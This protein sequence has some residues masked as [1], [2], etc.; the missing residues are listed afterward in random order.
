MSGVYGSSS[1]T[2]SSLKMRLAYFEDIT[3][4]PIVLGMDGIVKSAIVRRG[5]LQEVR[6][7]YQNGDIEVALLPTPDALRA[8][9]S[10]LVPASATSAVGAS[11]MFM[12]FSKKLP[13]EIKRVLVDENDLGSEFLARMLLSKKLMMRPEFV[14]SKKP[15]DPA[16][17]DLM[18]PDGFD[19]YLLVGRNCFFVRRDAFAFSMDLTMAWYELTKLPYV[20][21]CW[22]VRKG[23][24]L[25]TMEREIG[26]V[27]RR[28]EASRELVQ[29]SAERSR[30]MESGVR[31]VY[32]KA[33]I[34]RFDPQVIASLR[35]YAKEL[36][37]SRILSV[38]PMAV[39]TPPAT[40]KKAGTV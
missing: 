38:Q 12:L 22:V 21:N 11:R 5:T 13:T 27:A 36:M 4:L 32:E 35:L 7:L 9:N 30:V 23:L 34:S 3:T 10:V 37:M 25:G 19:A 8:N 17:Y 20:I 40:M 26:D 33:L 15:L 39:Y 1:K 16:E 28:N 31:A 6:D 18:Q 24:V 2:S 14:R 29:K